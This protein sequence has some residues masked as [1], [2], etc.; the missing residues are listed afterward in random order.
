MAMLL[1]LLQIPLTGRASKQ[2]VTA[3][4]MQ[5]TQVLNV[6]AF[7]LLRSRSYTWK[8]KLLRGVVNAPCKTPLL[9]PKSRK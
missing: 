4:I 9:L 6:A 5:Y 8:C 7:C 2:V 1:M 3:H